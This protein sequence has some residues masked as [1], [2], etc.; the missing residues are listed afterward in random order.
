M[1][2]K[3]LPP[4]SFLFI[5]MPPRPWLSLASHSMHKCIVIH[6]AWYSCH[7]QI[8][9]HNMNFIMYEHIM[10]CA[11]YSHLIPWA[12]HW[13]QVHTTSAVVN[14]KH[15]IF[16]YLHYKALTSAI[17][18]HLVKSMF[19]KHIL[20][21]VQHYH[22]PAYYI[23]RLWAQIGSILHSLQLLPR[24]GTLF[25]PCQCCSAQQGT[26]CAS[27]KGWPMTGSFNQVSL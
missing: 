22:N 20:H 11:P 5:R 24:V 9:A 27:R 1:L 16:V 15:F 13:I 2:C 23:G 3:D 6:F 18:F 7:A 26:Y 19:T 14:Q 21:K 12:P 25:E 8:N 10:N 4:F 17:A